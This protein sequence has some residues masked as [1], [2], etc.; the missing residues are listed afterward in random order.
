MKSMSAAAIQLGEYQPFV[1]VISTEKRIQL[2]Y[3]RFRR[4]NASVGALVGSAPYEERPMRALATNRIA[5]R[6]RLTRRGWHSF[7]CLALESQSVSNYFDMI[8]GVG[9]GISNSMSHTLRQI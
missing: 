8:A 4:I 9:M 3:S 2:T 5:K 1:S 6:Q 7:A